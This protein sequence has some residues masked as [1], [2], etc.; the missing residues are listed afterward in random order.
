[1]KFYHMKD[2]QS[3]QVQAVGISIQTGGRIFGIVPSAWLRNGH[4]WGPYALRILAPDHN[5]G[6][7]TIFELRI[8]RLRVR[9]M[10][11]GETVPGHYLWNDRGLSVRFLPKRKRAD[12]RKVA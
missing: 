1:M 8:L 11:R 9:W 7:R 5:C 6:M 10:S 4:G 3:A 2:V 12:L